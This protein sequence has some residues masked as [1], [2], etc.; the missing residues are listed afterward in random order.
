MES[1]S[2]MRV[3]LLGILIG[4]VMSSGAFAD[5]SIRRA[6]V[7]AAD[8]E[9]RES[10]R[11]EIVATEIEPGITVGQLVAKA[12]GAQALQPALASAE[13]IGGTRWIDDQTCQ[14]QLDVDGKLVRDAL[15]KTASDHPDHLPI[16][17]T[18][19]KTRLD[20][21]SHRSFSGTGTSTALAVAEQLR[22]ADQQ[23]AWAAV[24]DEDRRNAIAA[25]RRNAASRILDAIRPIT[26]PDGKSL[27]DALEQPGV[28]SAVSG[29]LANRPITTIEFR[30]DLEVRLTIAAEEGDLWQVIR[31]ALPQQTAVKLPVGEEGWNRLKDQVESRAA[32]PVGRSVAAGNAA[33]SAHVVVA[34]PQRPP[35]WVAQSI[36][37]EGVARSTGR[38]LKTARI[39][40]AVAD[41]KLAA[42]INDL[43]LGPH[44]TIE[45]AA[46]QDPRVAEAVARALGRA[47]A[48]KIDYDYPEAGAVRVKVGLD[49]ADLWQELIN[50]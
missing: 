7:A 12:G 42:K 30:D 6:Q 1:I 41:E 34:V 44:L 16:P 28:Q 36:D 31:A 13:Q 32:V 48:F 27:G 37:V 50:R 45:Q 8:A 19:L 21:W 23:S 10:L 11:Q 25:A 4:L 29:W 3:A 38:L 47:R 5:D 40:E 26:M 15:L 24:R 14:V 17:L 46:H 33:V 39:A 35:T 9:A 2:A 43:P 18:R 22:P 49:L 20:Q